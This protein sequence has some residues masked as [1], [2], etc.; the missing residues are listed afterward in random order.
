MFTNSLNDIL[1]RLTVW[2]PA[3]RAYSKQLTEKTSK[4]VVLC[5][6]LNVAH[7]DNDIYNYYAKHMEKTAGCTM[8]ERDNFGMLL[9][10]GYM[11]ALRHFHPHARGQYTYWSTRADNRPENKGLRIDY[12]VCSSTLFDGG[13][14]VVHDSYVAPKLTSCSDHCPI[15]LVII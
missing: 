3:L 14:N 5:G 11:D 13:A 8:R 4:P 7:K 15:G 10:S 6:D 2:D 12:F 1:S 9:D